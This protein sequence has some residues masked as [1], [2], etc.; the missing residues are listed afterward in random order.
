MRVLLNLI[1]CTRFHNY[2]LHYFNISKLT[3][4]R[5]KFNSTHSNSDRAVNESIVP[6]KP[7]TSSSEIYN[8]EKHLSIEFDEDTLLLLERLSLVGINSR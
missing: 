6:Q 4:V 1:N 7:H 8:R 3:A 2:Y 5:A